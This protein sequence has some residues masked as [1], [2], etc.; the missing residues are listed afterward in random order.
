MRWSGEE[1]AGF[2]APGVEPWL[3][4]GPSVPNVADAEAD[5]GSTLHLVR[6]LIAL[7]REF[8]DLRSGRY[9]PLATADGVWA[10]TRGDG[11]AIA[12]NLSDEAVRVD[13]I[14]G[15]V[16]VAT[17]RGRDGERVTDGLAL[18]PWEAAVVAL[19]T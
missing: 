16:R 9:R 6:D 7:R 3:P 14:A 19:A 17:D 18:S 2:T 13:A 10:W 8:A 12:L 4:F 15:I 1:G 11:V 5:G